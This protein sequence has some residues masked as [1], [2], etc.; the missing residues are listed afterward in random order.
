MTLWDNIVSFFDALI[1]HIIFL[2]LLVVGFHWSLFSLYF[3]TTASTTKTHSPTE[4]AVLAEVERLAREEEI[5]NTQQRA[6]RYALEIQKIEF[7]QKIV[8][9][10]EEKEWLQ[11]QQAVEL[12]ALEQL[13]QRQ[14]SQE[15]QLKQLEQEIARF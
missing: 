12:K 4:A 11:E 3:S 2:V 6:N 15:R 10:Q 5:K 8:E 7:E 13:K 14:L 1:I 9:K